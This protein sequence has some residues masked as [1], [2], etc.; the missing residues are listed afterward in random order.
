MSALQV[1]LFGSRYDARTV[2]DTERWDKHLPQVSR[3]GAGLCYDVCC[4][5]DEWLKLP[6]IAGRVLERYV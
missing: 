5:A 4:C 1:F 6:I 2:W 3:Y